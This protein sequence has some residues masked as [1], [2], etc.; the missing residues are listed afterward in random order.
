MSEIEWTPD[1]FET[2]L[3]GLRERDDRLERL[4]P[5]EVPSRDEAVDEY[6]FSGHVEALHSEDIDGDVWGTLA[7]LDLTAPSE[8]RAW[9]QIKAFYLERGCVLLRVDG[10]EYLVGEELAGRL[11]MLILDQERP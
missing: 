4:G 9:E 7:D 5:G 8:E 10:D 6:V 1:A 2:F 3:S 11:G